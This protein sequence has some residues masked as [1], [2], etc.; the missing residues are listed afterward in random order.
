[1]FYN[2]CLGLVVNII[3]FCISAV[4]NPDEAALPKSKHISI[5]DSSSW[6]LIYC[7]AMTTYEKLVSDPE[8]LKQIMTMAFCGAAG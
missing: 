1:M 6:Y 3:A 4:A 5:E 8:L 7:T 2:N